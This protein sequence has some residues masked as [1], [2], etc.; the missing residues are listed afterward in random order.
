MIEPKPRAAAHLVVWC[1][2]DGEGALAANL[3]GEAK[4]GHLD[5][6]LR[7]KQKD[8]RAKKRAAY[9]CLV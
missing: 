4:V 8:K 6:A 1:A 5:V 2:A 3:L 7:G 9:A